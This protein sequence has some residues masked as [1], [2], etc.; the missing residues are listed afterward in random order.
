M[1]FSG[2]TAPGGW[3]LN[4]KS[5]FRIGITNA[6]VGHTAGTLGGTNVESRGGGGVV[7]GG[8]ARAWNNPLFTSHYG[9]MPGKYDQGGYLQPGMNLA[10]NGTGMPEPVYTSQ[11]AGALTSMAARGGS[12]IARFE[13]DLVLDS[14]EFL[15]RVRGEAVEVIHETLRPVAAAMRAGIPLTTW[16]H[17][18]CRAGLDAASKAA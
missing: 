12:Q 15:G 1:A 6:G 8:R 10:Y 17:L 2:K 7:I 9:F 5:P 11:Q 4:G 3:V 18:N 13:G 14:G 16:I